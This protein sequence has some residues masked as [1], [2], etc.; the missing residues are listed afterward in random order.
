[1]SRAV[2]SIVRSSLTTNGLRISEEVMT[3]FEHVLDSLGRCRIRLKGLVGQKVF[4]LTLWVGKQVD[5]TTNGKVS[6]G[7]KMLI[8]KKKTKSM[9]TSNSMENKLVT[10]I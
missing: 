2:Q 10:S 5:K 8:H 4:E 3:V 7:L 6:T 9:L 1:M